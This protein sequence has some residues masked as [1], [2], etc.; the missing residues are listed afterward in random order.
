MQKYPDSQ[1]QAVI[2][3]DIVVGRGQCHCTEAFHDCQLVVV[4]GGPGAGKTAIIEF[5]RQVFCQHVAMVPE[6][7]SIVF[8]GGFWRRDSMPSQKA[9]QRAIYHVQRELETCLK[10]EAVTAAGLCDRGTIDGVAYWPGSE[11]S[12]WKELG[13]TREK[14]MAR[15]AAVIHLRTPTVQ[16]G[17]N[18]SNPL[19]IESADLAA[20]ID[21]KILKAWTGHKRHIV[22]DSAE[23][24]MAKTDKALTVIRELLPKC[25]ANHSL[26][27]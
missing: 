23:S 17:Y 21:E 15:Y 4:T 25:C 26:R 10:E 19:R 16:L 18:K 9:A 1:K 3:A 24:F 14:E 12:Y 7:A 11:D 13:S 6:A 5:A 27:P 8:G 22:I 2:G 20:A